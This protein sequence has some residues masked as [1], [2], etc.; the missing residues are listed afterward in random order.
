MNYYDNIQRAI[1]YIELNLKED[2]DVLLVIQMSH[3]SITHFYRIFQAMVGDSVK[4]Y[5]QKRRLSN[6]A[7]E[8]VNSNKR[9]ID[10]AFEYGYNSQEVFTR[11]FNKA[12][13]ITPGKYRTQKSKVVLYKKINVY[14]RMLANQGRI[15]Y[16][17]PQ[18]IL[19]K[20]FKL[21]GMKE[22]VKPGSER[23]KNLWDSFTSKKSEIKNILTQDTVLG[24]CEYMPNI[25]DES[26]FSYF[27]GVE[28]KDFSDIPKGMLIKIIPNSKYAVFTHKG[29][30]SKL[31]DTYNFI[32]GVWLPQSGYELAE[33]D[34][35]ELYDSRSNAADSE[36]DIHIPLKY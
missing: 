14:E 28:V 18:I 34:T 35:I 26:E 22:T 21:I 36:F 15:I 29:S 25:T 9:L 16:I 27:A 13:N 11:A 30:L 4:S 1:D 23:I 17:E 7:T 3:F 8:L 24:I 12:F 32:Y 20:E 2:I 5:I 6:I 10:V 31:K 19:D 33:L